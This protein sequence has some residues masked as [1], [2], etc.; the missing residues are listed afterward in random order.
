MGVA[1]AAKKDHGEPRR[2]PRKMNAVD[3]N[4]KK[5]LS[6]RINAV[7]MDRIKGSPRRSPRKRNAVEMDGEKVSPTGS[8]RKRNA[9]HMDMTR[10]VPT[11]AG[12]SDESTVDSLTPMTKRWQGYSSYEDMCRAK[13]KRNEARI[14]KLGILNKINNKEEDGK[15]KL[16]LKKKEE[17][18]DYE[19]ENNEDSDNDTIYDD[20]LDNMGATNENNRVTRTAKSLEQKER[21]R[22]DK[23][24]KSKSEQKEIEEYKVRLGATE[25]C[26]RS[27]C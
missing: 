18:P 15:E 8:P 27:K 22:E 24:G 16:D 4:G 7:D 5:E 20:T 14:A 25:I 23:D 1:S 21:M 13:W 3:S 6:R 19:P 26:T 11:P 10:L 12:R 17:D 2:S 9:D